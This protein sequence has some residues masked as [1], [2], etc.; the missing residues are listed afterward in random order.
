MALIAFLTGP[1]GQRIIGAYQIA[2]QTLF[3]PLAIPVPAAK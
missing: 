3:H 1:E 2:G